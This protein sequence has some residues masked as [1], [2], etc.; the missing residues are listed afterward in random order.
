MEG[1]K[2]RR[3]L[4]KVFRLFSGRTLFV[5]AQY[6][7]L[8]LIARAGGAEMLG[9]Y[10]IAAAVVTPVFMFARMRLGGLLATDTGGESPES[11]LRLQWQLVLIA[12]AGCTLIA[13]LWVG[14]N[15]IFGPLLVLA[16]IRGAEA[17]TEIVH[18]QLQ[19]AGRAD[20]MGD[21]YA[22]KAFAC[23]SLSIAAAALGWGLTVIL[24]GWLAGHVSV[25]ASLDQRYYR[26]YYHTVPA[27][28][29]IVTRSP[30]L[31]K[32]AWPLG[33]V[34]MISAAA[35]NV[36]RYFL[37]LNG[38]RA[39]VGV[40]TAVYSVL[41]EMALVN[42]LLGKLATA[43]MNRSSML[44]TSHLFRTVGILMGVS[45]L[46][47]LTGLL[48]AI[49]FG[50][51]VLRL[52]FGDEFG[53]ATD[54]LLVLLVASIGGMANSHVKR[55]LLVRRRIAVQLLTVTASVTVAALV[56]YW[57]IPRMGLIGAGWSMVGVTWTELLFGALALVWQRRPMPQAEYASTGMRAQ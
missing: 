1:T 38:A 40:F 32:R 55:A 20:L 22:W 6:C 41:A 50:G 9:E 48:L 27:A 30:Q 23:A 3:R 39:A 10:G 19:R 15:G 28:S 21:S 2:I 33:F 45:A 7:L 56:A 49:P 11:Y 35:S 8:V 42:E 17:I 4:R 18:G 16:G 44:G 53:G 14:A 24:L 54:L 34:A 31:L 43:R 26:R 46:I 36:P 52:L 12:I 47:G 5:A 25:L 29:P 37:E 51:P 13:T 57:T